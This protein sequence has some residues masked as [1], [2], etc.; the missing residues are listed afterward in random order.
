MHHVIFFS[1][2]RDKL[3]LPRVLHCLHVFCEECIDGL[4]KENE[5]SL[6]TNTV[7]ECPECNQCTKVSINIE[8]LSNIFFHKCI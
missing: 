6:I 8:F 5:D 2:L 4:S 1:S 3:R 7:I